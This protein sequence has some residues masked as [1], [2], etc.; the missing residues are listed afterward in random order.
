MLRALP[1][2]VVL[3]LVPSAAALSFGSLVPESA[4][5]ASAGSTVEF[6]VLLWSSEQPMVALL[7][8]EAPAGWDVLLPEPFA[9]DGS[10]P[11]EQVAHAGGYVQARKATVTVRVPASAESGG[12]VTVTAVVSEPGSGIRVQQERSY[13]FAVLLEGEAAP[14]P[15]PEPVPAPQPIPRPAPM[16]APALVP[17]PPEAPLLWYALG[18]LAI[19]AACIAIYRL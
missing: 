17:A 8:Q 10:G 5:R 1:L 12:V 9:L 4:A 16:P 11:T 13:R 2:L 3:V 14:A 7:V 6:S 15:M 18:I 19:L